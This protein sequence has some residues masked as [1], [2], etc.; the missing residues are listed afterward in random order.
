MHT[1]PCSGFV[2]L[3]EPFRLPEETDQQ[4]A[5]RMENAAEVCKRCPLL[6]KLNCIADAR[7][8]EMPRGVRGGK[9]ITGNTKK[10]EKTD[11]RI[12]SGLH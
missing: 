10:K 5:D 12:C 2:R 6:E 7:Q 4:R 11:V 1:T 3:F 9:I 8:E